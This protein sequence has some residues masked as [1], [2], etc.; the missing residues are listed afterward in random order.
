THPAQ[1]RCPP[2]RGLNFVNFVKPADTFSSQIDKVDVVPIAPYLI[3]KPVL[4]VRRD[5]SQQPRHPTYHL[6]PV[7]FLKPVVIPDHR[8]AHGKYLCI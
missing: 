2:R 6:H 7:A 5:L 8:S 4:G 3:P 1:K